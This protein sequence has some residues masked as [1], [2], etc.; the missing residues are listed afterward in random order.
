MR[1]APLEPSPI[2]PVPRILISAVLSSSP[3]LV[4]ICKPGT[5]PCKACVAEVTGRDSNSLAVASPTAPVRFTFF[6]VPN[7]T[8]TTS[9]RVSVS[10]FNTTLSSFF[11]KTFTS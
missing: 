11:P 5:N 8:T 4:D 1:G 9:S 6:C 2:V 10:S 7:P 3:V